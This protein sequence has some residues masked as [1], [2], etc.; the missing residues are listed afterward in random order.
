MHQ[1]FF[2]LGILPSIPSMDLSER[3]R[4]ATIRIYPSFFTSYCPHFSFRLPTAFGV[5]LL[6]SPRDTI[7]V[8][9]IEL[10]SIPLERSLASIVLLLDFKFEKTFSRFCALNKARVLISTL[11]GCI[12]MVLPATKTVRFAFTIGAL[13]GA[14]VS[15]GSSALFG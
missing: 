10:C 9:F 8:P 11:F 15:R 1:I 4:I 12:S 3:R 14:Q 5:G 7:D 13:D 2:H 6:F